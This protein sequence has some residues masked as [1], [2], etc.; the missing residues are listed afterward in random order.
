MKKIT[1]RKI[2]YSFEKFKEAQREVRRQTNKMEYWFRRCLLL[3]DVK[4][5]VE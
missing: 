4:E 3:E 5:L 2:N 1:E